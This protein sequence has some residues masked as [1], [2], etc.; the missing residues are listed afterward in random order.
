MK[1][2]TNVLKKKKG[3]KVSNNKVYFRFEQKETYNIL[4]IQSFYIYKLIIIMNYKP[5]FFFKKIL[6]YILSI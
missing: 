6:M 1:Y 5:Y 3:Q 4:T 2:I